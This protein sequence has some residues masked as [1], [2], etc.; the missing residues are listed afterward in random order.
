LKQKLKIHYN[1]R[2]TA[3][4]PVTYWYPKLYPGAIHPRACPQELTPRSFPGALP[5]ELPRVSPQKLPRSFVQSASPRAL[6]EL[7]GE[8][9]NA[10]VHYYSRT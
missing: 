1:I 6:P 8:L 4:T 10:P 3:T 2:S 5:Q 9:C 7:T